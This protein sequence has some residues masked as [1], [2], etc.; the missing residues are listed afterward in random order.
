MRTRFDPSCCGLLARA[1]ATIPRGW[2][3]EGYV[4]LAMFTWELL[5]GRGCLREERW[6][7]WFGYKA[8]FS[9]DAAHSF[10]GT[11]CERVS[12]VG[13]SVVRGSISF[14]SGMIISFL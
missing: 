6:E 1:E 9:S 8:R 14:R 10:S 4:F 12:F 11:L 3:C 13:K 7:C 2:L 5:R